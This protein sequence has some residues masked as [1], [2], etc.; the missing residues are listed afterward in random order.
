MG[1]ENLRIHGEAHNLTDVVDGTGEEGAKV[2]NLIP[3]PETE[4]RLMERDQGIKTGSQADQSHRSRPREPPRG[5]A[6][7]NAPEAQLQRRH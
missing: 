3:A 5:H 2:D 6:L 4:S 7:H 1:T